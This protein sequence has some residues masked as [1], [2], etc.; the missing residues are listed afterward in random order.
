MPGFPNVFANQTSPSMGEL[1]TNFQFAAM[2]GVIPCTASGTNTYALTPSAVAPNVT[3]YQNY[4]LF[5]WVVPNASTSSVAINVAGLGAI[6]LYLPSG[7]QAGSGAL[8]S[9]DLIICAYNSTIPS[10]VIVSGPAVNV[11]T[12]FNSYFVTAG[13]SINMGT[14]APTATAK[15]IF[16]FTLVGGGA[17]GGGVNTVSGAKA[18]GG[19]SGQVLGFTAKGI[20]GLTLPCTLGFAGS[21]GSSAGGTG[22]SGGATSIAY[23]SGGNTLSATTQVSTGGIGST[24]AT[25]AALGGA[26]SGSAATVSAGGIVSIVQTLQ[27]YGGQV[28]HTGIGGTSGASGAGGSSPFGQGGAGV[29]GSSGGLPG[30]GYGSG[31]SGAAGTGIG[32]TGGIAATGCILIEWNG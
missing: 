6:P 29:S 14:V 19:A 26:L 17:G 22:V 18:G 15:T 30:L 31:G 9:G 7:I 28:G 3:S 12:Q 25:L 32:Q 8:A 5:S 16:R 24:S 13:S 2:L 10:A 1:D 21:G 23:S 11:P 20:N 27:T 4:M